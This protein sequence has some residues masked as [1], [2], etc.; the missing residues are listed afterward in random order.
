MINEAAFESSERTANQDGVTI[1]VPD[2]D[3]AVKCSASP[4]FKLLAEN[5]LAVFKVT[6][7]VSADAKPSLKEIHLAY[8]ACSGHSESDFRIL[9][10]EE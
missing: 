2:F 10:I 3:E 9:V 8:S 5:S 7:T 4:E 1:T 6:I